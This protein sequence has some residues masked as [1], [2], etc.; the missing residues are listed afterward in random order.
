MDGNPRLSRLAHSALTHPSSEVYL[1]A[2]SAWEIVLKYA[3]GQLSLS[4]PPEEYVAGQRSLHG[5]NSLPI[6][7]AAMFGVMELPDIHRDPFDRIIIAQVM[8]D[9]TVIVTSDGLIR[10]YPVSVV[11]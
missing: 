10:R 9:D 8:A 4:T 3:K 6:D 11:W 7:E 5:I 1:S 2:A